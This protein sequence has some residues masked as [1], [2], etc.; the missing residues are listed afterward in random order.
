[1]IQQRKVNKLSLV[2][3]VQVGIWEP[4]SFTAFFWRFVSS[5]IVALDED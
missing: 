1:M 4:F 2:D 5:D 3:A